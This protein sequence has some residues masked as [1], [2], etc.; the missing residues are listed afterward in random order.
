MATATAVKK[1]A[2]QLNE[3]TATEIVAAVEAGTVTC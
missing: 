3:L 1:A 2:A